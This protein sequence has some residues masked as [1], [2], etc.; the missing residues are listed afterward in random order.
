MEE[1]YKL[2][3]GHELSH[4]D[5][6]VYIQWKINDLYSSGKTKNKILLFDDSILWEKYANI[7]LND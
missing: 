7:I 3:E 6:I 2:E 1:L 4:E 5:H